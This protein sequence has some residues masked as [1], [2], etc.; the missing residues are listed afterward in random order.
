MCGFGVIGLSDSGGSSG[1]GKLSDP[2]DAVQLGTVS[3]PCGPAALVSKPTVWLDE[4]F[5]PARL[6]G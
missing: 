5:L 3:R 6:S 1:S 4:K 2:G